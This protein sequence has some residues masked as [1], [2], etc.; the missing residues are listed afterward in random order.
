MGNEVVEDRTEGEISTSGLSILE[1]V[2]DEF[3]R[4]SRDSFKK[5]LEEVIEF[6]DLRDPHR[7]RGKIPIQ[8]GDYTVVYYRFSPPLNPLFPAL[9]SL[10][11]V[12]VP[13]RSPLAAI[14][15]S[16]IK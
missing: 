8:N 14:L 3:S 2:S 5:S 16:P 9:F 11:R 13:L 10:F 6:L 1:G 4:R 15:L 12:F 7:F